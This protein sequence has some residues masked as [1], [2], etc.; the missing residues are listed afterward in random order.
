MVVFS[1]TLLNA[2]LWRSHIFVKI[3]Y[4]WHYLQI[5][6]I[7]SKESGRIFGV[8]GARNQKTSSLWEFLF[9]RG[10]LRAP[11]ANSKSTCLTKGRRLCFAYPCWL[12]VSGGHSRTPCWRNRELWLFYRELRWRMVKMVWNAY[13]MAIYEKSH[14]FFSR[15]INEKHEKVLD[16]GQEKIFWGSDYRVEHDFLRRIQWCGHHGVKPGLK[17]RFEG[18]GRPKQ[19]SKFSGGVLK[20]ETPY[21][22]PL[23]LEKGSWWRFVEE[24]TLRAKISSSVTSASGMSHDNPLMENNVVIRL[25]NS[26]ARGGGHPPPRTPPN[27]VASLHKWSRFAPL[28]ESLRSIL[29]RF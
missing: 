23:E 24:P 9:C 29:L 5:F 27:R 2:E 7:K 4:A 6:L 11:P 26:I 20:R 14:W 16:L 3:T 13:G 1:Q 28:V 25:I 15:K 21:G 10:P 17:N 19:K 12:R 22:T 18:F 8:P